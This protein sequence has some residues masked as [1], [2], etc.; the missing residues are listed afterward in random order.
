MMLLSVDE[1]IVILPCGMMS[2]ARLNARFTPAEEPGM[3]NLFLLILT[4]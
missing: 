1:L 3:Q 2:T 4:N